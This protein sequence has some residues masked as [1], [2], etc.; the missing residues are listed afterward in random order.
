MQT[1]TSTLAASESHQGRRRHEVRHLYKSRMALQYNKTDKDKKDERSNF[2]PENPA[3]AATFAPLL[4]VPRLHRQQLGFH[5]IPLRAH[6]IHLS[7]SLA[8]SP[9][10]PQ[11]K[12]RLQIPLPLR[13]HLRHHPLRDSGSGWMMY[14][15]F[16]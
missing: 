1:L 14:D 4:H 10:L 3:L 15:R 11:P 8:S 13:N 2:V 12:S 6:T 16:S 5:S 9:L 7:L